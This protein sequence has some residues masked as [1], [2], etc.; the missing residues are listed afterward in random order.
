MQCTTYGCPNEAQP[1]QQR[2]AD[3]QGR[4]DRPQ[5]AERP[6]EQASHDIQRKRKASEPPSAPGLVRSLSAP[7]LSEPTTK[8]R[9]LGE[10]P[11]PRLERQGTQLL[12]RPSSQ[13]DELP[14]LFVPFEANFANLM[15]GGYQR[16]GNQK[17]FIVEGGGSDAR[18]ERNGE[19]IF[20]DMEVTFGSTPFWSA[21]KGEFEKLTLLAAN[22]G[23]FAER[24]KELSFDAKKFYSTV[25]E[26]R[27]RHLKFT[28]FS[29]PEQGLPEVVILSER[30]LEW[31]DMLE[32]LQLRYH[33]SAVLE[34]GVA[35]QEMAAYVLHSALRL[36]SF[37]VVQRTGKFSKSF[38]E[39]W[40]LVTKGTLTVACVHL[41]SQYTKA[42]DD[43]F[44]TVFPDLVEFAKNNDTHA[45]MG[46]CNMNTYGVH[47]GS[48]P[49]S[50]EFDSSSGG[51]AL[52]T[53]FATSSGS[54]D[55][56]YMGGMICDPR[57]SFSSTLD[58]F[59][60]CAVPPWFTNSKLPSLFRK[61]FSDHHSLYCRYALYGGTSLLGKPRTEAGGDCF[62]DALKIRLTQRGHDWRTRSVADLR[63][64]VIDIIAPSI[65]SEPNFAAGRSVLRQLSGTNAAAPFW[66][67]TPDDFVAEMR[68]PGRWVEDTILP[69]IALNVQVQ[70]VIQYANGY[71]VFDTGGGRTEH[72]GVADIALE[73]IHMN[74]QG[75][76]FW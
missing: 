2:C 52:K 37:K 38:K 18:I 62:F 43:D 45:I 26:D 13:R 14:I 4:G 9:R 75:N 64:T 16:T 46:D 51:S 68:Q 24:L 66:C 8:K 60:N 20:G 25:V 40:L 30:L 11:S 19:L 58:T 5:R 49:V 67:A 32:P 76:H 17:A 56:A 53:T 44:T 42:K 50:S 22:K 57:V 6:L 34:R 54:G 7:E 65:R 48:F 29:Q 70:F 71:A 63:T 31:P 36:Y 35:V 12:V 1:G 74:C 47:G 55:K 61:V 72:Q 39:T 69:L 10:R 27:L 33:K 73:G 41:S 28:A 21:K 59:G 15:I 23:Q 3:C